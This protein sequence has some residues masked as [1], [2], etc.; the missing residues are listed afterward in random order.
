MTLKTVITS[1]FLLLPPAN[2]QAHTVDRLPEDKNRQHSVD[3]RET[4]H[5]SK[6]EKCLRATIKDSA[7]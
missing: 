7:P 5:E 3:V 4:G 2:L 1:I 6:P